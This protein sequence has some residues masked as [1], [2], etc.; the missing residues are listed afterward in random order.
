M[1]QQLISIVRAPRE[2]VF[3]LHTDEV[4]RSMRICDAMQWKRV[5]ERTSQLSARRGQAVR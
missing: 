4:Y 5:S 1:Q 2:G 3:T